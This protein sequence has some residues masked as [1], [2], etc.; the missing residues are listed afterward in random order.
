MPLTARPRLLGVGYATEG[1]GF[2]R[3]F[4]SLYQR[5]G[6]LWEI[7][8]LEF[9]PPCP[10]VAAPQWRV[11]FTR[12]PAVRLGHL[13]FAELLDRCRPDLVF[14]SVD[15]WQLPPYLRALAGAVAAP[16]V[17]AYCPVDAPL[18]S[19]P[20]LHALRLLDC[21]AVPTRFGRDEVTSALARQGVELA[22]PVEVIPHGIDSDKFYPYA[23]TAE[24]KGRQRARAE[25]FPHR[26]ELANA[27][28]VLNGNRNQPRK[29]LDL[30]LQGF[31]RFAAGKPPGVKL[32]LH[33]GT[34][35]L[36]SNTVA[37]ANELGVLDR[38][39]RTQNARTHPV[40]NDGRL[41]LIYNACEVG[42]NTSMSEGWGLVAFEHAATGAAQIVPQHSACGELWDGAATLLPATPFHRDGENVEGGV[43]SADAL[44][45]T[46]ERLYADRAYLAQQS[47]AAFDNAHRRDLEWGAVA[48]RFE[49][50]FADTLAA[51]HPARAAAPTS[52]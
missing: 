27:F 29:R 16:R 42:V 5:L 48:C 31:A 9:S 34:I 41:N 46:L 28:I 25:L 30:T 19:C 45:E 13:E 3:V 1:F 6:P 18:R 21:L 15:L 10:P 37:V 26:P 49:S 23:D 2:G 36:G 40:V 51:T 8:H 47:R 39:L 24:Q 4:R 52:A 17:I 32:L 22:A 7:E 35:D 44:A 33:S 43:V 14:F 12:R 20:D 11:H 38:V 50:L